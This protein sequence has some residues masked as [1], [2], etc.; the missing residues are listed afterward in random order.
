MYEVVLVYLDQ[1]QLVI[2]GRRVGSEGVDDTR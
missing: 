1:L 2:T